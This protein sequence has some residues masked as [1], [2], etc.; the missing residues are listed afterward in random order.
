MNKKKLSEMIFYTQIF[1]M[2]FDFMFGFSVDD[3]KMLKITCYSV[4]VKYELFVTK[5]FI[6]K[7]S[8]KNPDFVSIIDRKTKS[9]RVVYLKK[10]ISYEFFINPFI[11]NENVGNEVFGDVTEVIDTVA[12]E[13][14][15][16]LFSNHSCIETVVVV[17]KKNFYLNSIYCEKK[18]ILACENK[19][20]SKYFN[21]YKDWSLAD[22]LKI[23]YEDKIFW[24]LKESQLLK[25]SEELVWFLATEIIEVK[26]KIFTNLLTTPIVQQDEFFELIEKK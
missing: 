1:L 3:E 8:N 21:S 10:N 25:D 18:I 4:G 16:I 20:L 13:Q 11:L 17:E 9:G 7:L 23:N 19:L 12:I 6:L 14:K 15:K 2:V 24:V 22:L 5:N 26:S